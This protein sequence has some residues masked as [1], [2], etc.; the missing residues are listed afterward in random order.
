MKYIILLFFFAAVLSGCGGSDTDQNSN[1]K[2]TLDKNDKPDIGT[3]TIIA[4][5]LGKTQSGSGDLIEV[6]V[7]D[8]SSSGMSAPPILK[9]KKMML[10]VGNN[11]DVSSL[12][13]EKEIKL[14][15]KHSDTPGDAPNWQIINILK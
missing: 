14:K 7:K 15:L 3:A 5:I 2:L 10:R 1:K 8:A 9:D 11:V 6:L 4:E 12:E 13:N